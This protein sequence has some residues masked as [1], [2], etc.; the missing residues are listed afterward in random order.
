M[1]R[2]PGSLLPLEV[3]ILEAAS[4][5]RE[6]GEMEFHGYSIANRI[7]E[8]TSARKLTAYGTLYRALGRLEKQGLLESQWEDPATAEA[9]GRPRRRLYSI[10]GAAAGALADARRAARSALKGS[11]DRLEEGLAST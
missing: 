10:T 7:A 1:R 3:A 9:E 5:L 11:G 6:H 8:A 4:D 2:K